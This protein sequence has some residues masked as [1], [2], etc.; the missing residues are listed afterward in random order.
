MVNEDPIKH[1]EFIQN[2]ITR[3]ASNSFL[4]KG[5]TVT[6]VAALF[7]LA[8][9]NASSKFV[10]LA[11]FPAIIFWVLDAYYLR[12]ERLY[13]ALYNYIRM[14]TAEEIQSIGPFSMDVTKCKDRIDYNG[15]KVDSWFRIAFSKTT[16]LFYGPIIITIVII[17]LAIKLT[18]E[19]VVH[20]AT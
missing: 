8:A 14:K 17:A 18:N 15:K 1:L 9:Q 19:C 2:V 13:R 3:M 12:Q 6:L 11:L 5:W 16:L 10:I 4:L 20:L 7:A